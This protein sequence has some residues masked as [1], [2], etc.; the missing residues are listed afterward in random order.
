MSDEKAKKRYDEL[1]IKASVLE[2]ELSAG[3]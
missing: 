3:Y 2:E 1:V